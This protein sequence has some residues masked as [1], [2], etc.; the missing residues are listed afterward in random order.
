[1]NNLDKFKSIVNPDGN[2]W[3]QEVNDRLSKKSWIKK[4]AS[5][6][7]YIK[8]LMR[9]KGM[10]QKA[11]A[12]LM[13]VSPQQVNKILKGRENLTLETISK[14]EE[15]LEVGLMNIPSVDQ[16]Q[17]YPSET[18]TKQSEGVMVYR[19]SKE[20]ISLD[21]GWDNWEQENQQAL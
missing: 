16:Y 1:M 3:K 10:T 13:Q 17:F 14:L 4:S 15:C 20:T 7:L 18:P 11:L 21:T 9:Q 8:R 5:L 12:E 2:Q 6:A 19:S